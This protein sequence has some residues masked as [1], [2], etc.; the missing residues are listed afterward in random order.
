MGKDWKEAKPE[1]RIAAR[2]GIF[3]AILAFVG[4]LI[5]AVAPLRQVHNS[6]SPADASPSASPFSTVDSPPSPTRETASACTTLTTDL[7]SHA[8]AVEKAV[9]QIKRGTTVGNDVALGLTPGYPGAVQAASDTGS[10]LN[11]SIDAAQSG[12]TPIPVNDGGV[13]SYN[14]LRVIVSDI[15]TLLDRMPG[16]VQ[17]G[18]EAT[19][20]DMGAL[21]DRPA[22]LRAV[23]DSLSAACK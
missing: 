19:A 10:R 15:N 16:L 8:E 20:D 17:V 6:S 3:A 13:N 2:V 1:G 7:R 11:R 21:L 12:D 22:V 14:E 9:R 18:P 23:A 5:G 4:V